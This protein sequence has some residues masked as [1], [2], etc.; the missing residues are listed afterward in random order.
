MGEQLKLRRID[1]I[2]SMHVSAK[3]WDETRIVDAL[4]ERKSMFLS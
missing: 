1:A 3:T 4:D 2:K